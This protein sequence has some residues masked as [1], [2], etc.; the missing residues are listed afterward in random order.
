MTA[1]GWERLVNSP[2][3][4]GLDWL[5]LGQGG[6]WQRGAAAGPVGPR[7]GVVLAAAERL[8]RL[9]QLWIDGSRLGAAGLA[10][11]VSS[12]HLGS[13]RILRINHDALDAGAGEALTAARLPALER[14]ELADSG[15]PD[16]AIAALAGSELVHR[17]RVLDL[18]CNP[19]TAAAASEIVEAGPFHQ[20]ECLCLIGCKI[21][22]EGVRTLARSDAFPV[23]KSLG[24][25]HCGLTDSGAGEVVYARWADQLESLSMGDER[26]SARGVDQLR[27]KFGPRLDFVR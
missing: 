13:L 20:M 19:L 26:I 24:L 2:V 1:G 14:L 18:R 9:G 15:L 21:G 10:A 4:E 25:L 11:I 17:V 27:T 6:P 12:P 8:V 22:D 23:L 3:V 7:G 16:G 5:L